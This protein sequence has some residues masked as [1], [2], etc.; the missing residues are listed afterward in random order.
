MMLFKLSIK[1]LRKSMRDYA[2]YFATVI[3]GVAVFYIFN[4]IEKQTVMLNVSKSSY[5]IIDLINRTMSSISVFVA[6]ILGF[7]IVYASN[8]L[9]KRRKKEFGIYMILGMEKGKIARILIIE[10]LIIGII[11]L[12]V[13]ITVGIAGSQVMSIFVAN[14]FEADMSSFTFIV[15][16]SA[17]AKTVIYF[18]IMYIVVILLNT[19]V[20]GKAK[21]IDLINS[22]KKSEKNIAKNPILCTV[23]FIAAICILGNAYYMVTVKADQILS[24]T[25]ILREIIKGIVSTFLI[26]WSMS[27]LL[28]FFTQKAKRFYHRKLNCFTIRELGSRINT[29]VFSG[30]IICL[31]LFVT[32]SVLSSALSIR[33]AIND[34][35]KEMTPADVEFYIDM[36]SG[37]T[38]LDIFEKTG[39]D[40]SIFKDFVDI[41]SFSAADGSFTM[42]DTIGDALYDMEFSEDYVEYLKTISEEFIK[43]SDYNRVARIYGRKEYFLEDDEYM[44]VANYDTIVSVRNK[45]LKRGNIIEIGG[46]EYRPKYSECQDGF[47]DMASNNTNFGLIIIPDNTNLEGY[48]EEM[49][50]FIANYK[51]NLQMDTDDIAEYIDSDEFNNKINPSDKAWPS[52]KINSKTQIYNNSIGLTAMII[53][54]GIY[55]GIVFMISSSAILALKELSEASDNK[56]KYN[57]L[58]RIGVDERQIHH[59]LFTQSAVFFGLPLALACIHSIFGIK[60]CNYMFETFGN[61]GLIYSIFVTA[62]I[63]IAVYGVYFLITYS[64]SKRMIQDKK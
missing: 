46:K 62:G 43:V 57:I 11:S 33:K 31:M 19:F 40:T 64:C 7:L 10:T 45:G 1:N 55:V 51:E 28:L 21:L 41:I 2:V 23:V 18:V 4:S 52:I 61:S 34:N 27:G 22:G 37:S 59:S 16:K 17:I 48:K 24:T 3:I 5:D 13:G 58:R 44:I 54:I 36:H 38:V 14:M 30:G 35:L 50:Y 15:S 63:I 26:F 49:S 39:V 42:D 60:V 56:E 29:T 9:M 20:V 8:F 32:I 47:I 25:D 6:M 12:G 53:F